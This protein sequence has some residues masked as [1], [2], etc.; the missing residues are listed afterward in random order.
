MAFTLVTPTGTAVWPN[1]LFPQHATVLSALIAHV[2]KPP[3]LT[4]FALP[5]L[6]GT[7]AWPEPLLPQQATLSSLLIAHVWYAPGLAALNVV[8]VARAG[9]APAASI[10]ASVDAITI[11]PL[12]QTK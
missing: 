8:G 9:V 10:S 3:A 1:P 7:V 6:T 2:W 12:T 5:R 11:R 4:A